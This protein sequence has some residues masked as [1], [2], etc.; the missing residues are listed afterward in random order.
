MENVMMRQVRYD[1]DIRGL[2]ADS[3]SFIVITP[4]WNVWTVW[5]S[6]ELDF[7]ILLAGLSADRR[8]GIWIEDAIRE[9][10]A[11]AEVA[12]PLALKGS[13]I[14]ILP[15]PPRDLKAVARKEDVPGAAMLVTLPAKLRT[16]RFFNRGVQNPL[17]WPHSVNYLVDTVYQPSAK[18]P[19]TA[20]DAPSTLLGGIASGAVSSVTGAVSAAAGSLVVPA[21]L[22]V[23]AYLI[24]RATQ[25]D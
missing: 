9:G 19:I 22:L 17:P 7:S 6:E 14:E 13:Q 5:Q 4:G 16:I 20:G 25:K 24:Y 21:V 10:A 2:S 15:N 23:T 11:G 3:S 1:L 18:N 8:L 12:D